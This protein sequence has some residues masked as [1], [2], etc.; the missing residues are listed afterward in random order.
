MTA[1]HSPPPL[2]PPQ[3]RRHP[4]SA[5]L[6]PELPVELF[7][8]VSPTLANAADLGPSVRL[9]SPDEIS[10]PSLRRI[11]STIPHGSGLRSVRGDREGERAPLEPPAVLYVALSFILRPA[12]QPSET[13]RAPEEDTLCKATRRAEAKRRSLPPALTDNERPSERTAVRADNDNCERADV[14]GEAD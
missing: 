10:S 2:H 12:R 13:R 1:L 4:K 11:V 14:R 7:P 3:L 9:S 6:Q 8:L 5:H